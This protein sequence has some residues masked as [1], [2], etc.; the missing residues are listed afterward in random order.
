MKYIETR[1]N[2]NY[3]KGRFIKPKG[4]VNHHNY[5]TAEQII[6]QCTS[7]A[8]HYTE[9]GRV[10]P[11]SSYHVV[12]WKDGSRTIFVADNLRAWHAGDSEFKGLISCNNFMLGACFHGNSN[13]EP[14]TFAQIDSYIEWLA[15]RIV[16]WRLKYD[17]ITDH[18]AVAPG[19]K[20][21]LNPKEQKRILEAI[22]W[23]FNDINVKG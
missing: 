22:K 19:R 1:L 10:I 14:L 12:I 4:V 6:R 7:K 16:K 11:P 9:D 18:R 8:K 20:V 21:D 5:L 15:P 23:M 3:S 17:W 2:G 13:K